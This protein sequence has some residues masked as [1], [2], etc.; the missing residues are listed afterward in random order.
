MK[1]NS[2]ALN[3]VTVNRVAV[4][5]SMHVILSCT[6]VAFLNVLLIPRFLRPDTVMLPSAHPGELLRCIRLLIWMV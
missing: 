5:S 3:R 2:I 1:Q 6:L 4:N